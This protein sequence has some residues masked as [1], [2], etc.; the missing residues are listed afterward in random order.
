[1]SVCC[2]GL[3]ESLGLCGFPRCSPLHLSCALSC[4]VCPSADGNS[5][6]NLLQS[7][8]DLLCVHDCFQARAPPAQPSPAQPRMRMG[9][10][11]R[12][13]DTD[14]LDLKLLRELP[15][16]APVSGKERRIVLLHGVSS[17]LPQLLR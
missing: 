10:C 3:G 15:E 14:D 9:Y 11:R 16:R 1:M 17:A 2:C 12:S 8:D 4:A 7:V 13:M 5:V 6:L